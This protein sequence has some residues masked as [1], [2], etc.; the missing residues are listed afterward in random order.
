MKQNLLLFLRDPLLGSATKAGILRLLQQHV[1]FTACILET[2]FQSSQHLL[3]NLK[4]LLSLKLFIERVKTTG[5]SLHTLVLCF[6][7]AGDP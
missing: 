4:L 7:T 5:E 2:A 3:H 1:A 6:D